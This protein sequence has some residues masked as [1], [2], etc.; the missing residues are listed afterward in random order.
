MTD[1]T[2]IYLGAT[3]LFWLVVVFVYLMWYKK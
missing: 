3:I 2:D 1:M